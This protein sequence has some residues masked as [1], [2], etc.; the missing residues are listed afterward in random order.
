MTN[1]RPKMPSVS[2]ELTPR[3]ADVWAL[4][5]DGKSTREIASALGMSMGSVQVRLKNAREKMAL[6]TAEGLA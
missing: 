3:E 2:L 1:Q 5:R 4:F 6:R